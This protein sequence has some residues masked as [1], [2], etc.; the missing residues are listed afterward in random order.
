M[1]ILLVVPVLIVLIAFALSNRQVV[2]LGLWPTDIIIDAPLSTTILVAAGLFF[3]VGALMT[4]GASVV[5][6]SRAR[7]AER[8]V[9]QLEAEVRA[10]KSQ[11][12]SAGTAMALP[13]PG[14]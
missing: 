10:L 5:T 1:R 14:A 6:A 13:P 4:W 11:P 12:R 2:Q 3:I 7:Q 8:T 9:R